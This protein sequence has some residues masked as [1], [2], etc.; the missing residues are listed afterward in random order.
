MDL[1]WASI[2]GL[3]LHPEWLSHEGLLWPHGVCKGAVMTVV[4]DLKFLC[5]SFEQVQALSLPL[6]GTHFPE[7]KLVPVSKEI[8]RWDAGCLTL[9]ER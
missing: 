2:S 3:K 7:P 6:S 4:R 1:D 9:W 5:T 8:L